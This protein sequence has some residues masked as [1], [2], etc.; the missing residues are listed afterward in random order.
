ILTINTGVD[1]VFTGNVQLRIKGHLTI[2]GK[3]NGKGQGLAASA[4]GQPGYIGSTKPTG[5]V[6]YDWPN[7]YVW[8]INDVSTERPAVSADHGSFPSLTIVN[9]AGVLSG[10]PNDL[11]GTSGSQG[12]AAVMVEE[13]TTTPGGV[14]GAGG[15]G[16]VIVCRGMSYGA[17]GEID[18]SGNDGTAGTITPE[19]DFPSV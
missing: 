2:N 14:G 5:G 15:A 6:D 9:S 10:L 1:V 17:A 3:L 8:T 11:R 19:G 12:G 4:T 16:I 18:T 13:G 7:L